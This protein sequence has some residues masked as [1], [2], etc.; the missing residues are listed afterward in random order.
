MTKEQL[1]NFCKN[2]SY[3]EVLDKAKYDAFDMSEGEFTVIGGDVV[4]KEKGE[5]ITVG[6][7]EN[8]KFKAN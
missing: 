4:L 8:K 3:D 1:I 5:N 2:N 7:Y 6:R